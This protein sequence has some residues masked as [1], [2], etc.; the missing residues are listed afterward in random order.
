[1]VY[2]CIMAE[3][4]HISRAQ[5]ILGKIAIK[6]DSILD[7]ESRMDLLHPGAQIV[8]SE[9]LNQY[10]E[11]IDDFLKNIM[12]VPVERI[13]DSGF[14]CRYDSCNTKFFLGKKR[15]LAFMIHILQDIVLFRNKLKIEEYVRLF[16]HIINKEV[17]DGFIKAIVHGEKDRKARI[18][19]VRAKIGQLDNSATGERSELTSTLNELE[20]ENDLKEKSLKE[21]RSQS[22]RAGISANACKQEIEGKSYQEMRDMIGIKLPDDEQ[23]RREVGVI[24][25]QIVYL[26]N[27][28]NLCNVIK[29]RQDGVSETEIQEGINIHIGWITEV[30]ERVLRTIEI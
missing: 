23:S 14:M 5:E 26:R 3:N 19:K 2:P 15:V 10:N 7:I 18:N 29:K 17:L 22:S 16:G 8:D 21:L 6:C 25:R 20:A 4:E 30:L 9:D 24:L 13:I 28:D 11:M 27:L 1:M 12:N